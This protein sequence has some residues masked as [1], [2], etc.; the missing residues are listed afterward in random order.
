[1]NKFQSQSKEFYNKPLIILLGVFVALALFYS[2]IIPLFEGPDEDD[3]FRYAKFIA[4][5]RALPVQL[6]E[7]GG[8]VAGHQGWQPPLYYSLAAL[9][10]APIDRSDY[11]QHL[12]RNYAAT[13]VGDPACCGRNIYYHT[14]SE[15]FPYTR[16][17]LAVHLARLL[18]IFFG[19]ITVTATFGIARQLSIVNYQLSIAVAA[20]VAFNPSFLFASALVSN[21]AMLTAFSSLVVLMW[22]KLLTSR[23]ASGGVIA[24]EAKQSPNRTLEIALSASFDSISAS[25]RFRSGRLL[26]MTRSAVLLGALIGLGIL[27][28]PT[29]LGLIPFSIL[30]LSIVAWRKRDARFAIVGNAA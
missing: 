8:G 13:F 5:Q 25:L 19:A 22:V 17:T 26:A 6:F 20:L 30:V 18:S 11:E 27:T 23:T 29:A 9:V 21:D 1:M 7:P 15:N 10:I 16:T 28:K 4:D 14:D 24:S 12:W 2:T 3:H